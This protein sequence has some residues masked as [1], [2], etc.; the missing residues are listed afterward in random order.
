MF[1][2]SLCD[3]DKITIF[4][5]VGIEFPSYNFNELLIA[6]GSEMPMMQKCQLTKRGAGLSIRNCL[7][8]FVHFSEIRMNDPSPRLYN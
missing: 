7:P 8:A 4:I 1:F 5:N 3:I 2:S 6:S